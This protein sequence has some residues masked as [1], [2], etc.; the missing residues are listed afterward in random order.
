MVH[1]PAGVSGPE[2]TQGRLPP[3]LP[4]KLKDEVLTQRM[5]FRNYTW[6]P[7]FVTSPLTE[8]SLGC[9]ACH[10]P[11]VCH[12]RWMTHPWNIQSMG[13][14]SWNLIHGWELNASYSAQGWTCP[15]GSLPS[16][17]LK[18][19][20]WPSAL[21]HDNAVFASGILGHFFLT[22]ESIWVQVHI[23][24]PVFMLQ[25]HTEHLLCAGPVLGSVEIKMS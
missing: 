1:G 13:M 2:G 7:T 3:C 4:P 23:H 9:V 21:T 12:Q 22:F 6:R 19:P 10:S 18:Y 5:H 20:G 11:V 25:A 15:R 8:A 14:P 17:R 16:C 24:H